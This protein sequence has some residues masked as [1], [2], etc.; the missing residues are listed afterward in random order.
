MTNISI[1]SFSD[2]TME[3]LVLLTD[4][5][6]KLTS[7]NEKSLIYLFTEH[8]VLHLQDTNYCNMTQGNNVKR[9]KKECPV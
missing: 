2:I 3:T 6:H 4:T 8:F 5:V 7:S 1:T 9:A